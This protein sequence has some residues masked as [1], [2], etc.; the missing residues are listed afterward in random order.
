MK[1]ERTLE[2]MLK[3]QRRINQMRRREAKALMPNLS[4]S[5]YSFFLTELLCQEARSRWLRVEMNQNSYAHEPILRCWCLANTRYDIQCA[6]LDPFTEFG[7][8]SGLSGPLKPRA[9]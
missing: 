7:T 2:E 6:R 3:L 5:W 1:E 4:R 9:W 8:Y